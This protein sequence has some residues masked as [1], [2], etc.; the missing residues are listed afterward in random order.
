MFLR[1]LVRWPPVDIQV[2]LY[3]DRSGETPSVGGVKHKRGMPKIA[4]LVLSNAISQKRCKTEAKLVSITNRK[5][6][7]N[8]R[9]VLDDLERR[10]SLKRRV[11][12]PN[13]AA[14]GAD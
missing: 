11:I 4:I 2:K 6:H 5:S 8:S 9:L 12:S 13:S 10:N 3:R 14:F 7:M 1:H